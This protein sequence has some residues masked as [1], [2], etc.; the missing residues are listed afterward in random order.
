MQPILSVLV[1]KCR[2]IARGFQQAFAALRGFFLQEKGVYD[3]LSLTH[4]NLGHSES[5]V[6]E[7]EQSGCYVYANARA[8]Y[9]LSVQIIG[10]ERRNNAFPLV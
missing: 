2:D 4:L 5:I 8:H 7:Q 3:A 1:P 6:K 10:A 9:V